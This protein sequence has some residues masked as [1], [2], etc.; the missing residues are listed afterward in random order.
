MSTGRTVTVFGAYGYTGRFLVAELLARGDVPVLS[1][2]DA[3]K[4]QVLA[5]ACTGLETR[6]ATVEDAASLDRALA[7]AD[8]VINAAGPFAVTAAPLVEAALRARVP[9][10]DVTAE[11]ET[12]SDIFE[13][14]GEPARAAGVTVVP[15]MAFYGGLGDLLVTAAMGDWAAADEARIGYGLDSWNPTPGTRNTIALLQQRGAGRLLCYRDG[16]LDYYNEA[17]PT[18]TWAFPAPL[19]EQPVIGEFNL[20]DVATIPSHLKIPTVRGYLPLNAIAD[21][22]SPDT[23]APVAVDDRGRSAQRF[24]VDVVV[25]GGG[26]ERRA[27]AHGQDAYA[28]TAPLAVE[29]VHRI[30]SGRGSTVGVAAA[31]ALF[32]AAE[33]LH[34]LP[35]LRVEIGN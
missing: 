24:V 18:S 20:A 15:A 13:R 25:R 4:L 14:Y 30:L 34:A 27:C 5:E 21:A 8:A 35:D 31:G 29:A 33:F 10:V 23:P 12:V 11:V 16:R 1:G 3:A 32:D 7:G 2:R 22:T 28:I 17:P 19:G 9:Y 6:P 26:A